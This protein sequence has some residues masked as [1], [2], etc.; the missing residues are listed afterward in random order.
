MNK[1]WAILLMPNYDGKGRVELRRKGCKK[2]LR[3]A[4]INKETM[5]GNEYLSFTGFYIIFDWG[6]PKRETRYR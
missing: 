3:K 6:E 1:C 4:L 5:R 2:E